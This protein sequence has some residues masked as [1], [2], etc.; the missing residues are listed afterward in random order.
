MARK[1]NNPVKVILRAV[2]QDIFN[3]AG[4]FVGA[5]FVRDGALG[6][7][8]PETSS[9]VARR[10]AGQAR[11]ALAA[12][13]NADQIATCYCATRASMGMRCCSPP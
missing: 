8:P 7:A 10:A 13:V 12:G 5:S 6:G 3:S 9:S 11:A 1:G 2:A 4:F